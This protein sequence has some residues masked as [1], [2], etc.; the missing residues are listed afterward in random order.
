[1]TGVQTCA[2][3]ILTVRIGHENPVERLEATSV[4]TAQYARSDSAVASL[5]VVGPTH[6]DY[7]GTI[8]SVQAVAQYLS[9]ILGSA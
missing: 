6:M 7:P 4:I 1:M 3:P 5:G 2:L 8:A 9:R